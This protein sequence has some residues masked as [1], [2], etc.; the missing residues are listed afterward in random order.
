MTRP[1]LDG[2][3]NNQRYYRRHAK[4]N[5]ERVRAWRRA[6][7]DRARKRVKES[8]WRN[9]ETR[10]AVKRSEKF[11]KRRS[12][13][14]RTEIG[15]LNGRL[16]KQGRRGRGIVRLDEWLTLL[17]KYDHKCAY[18]GYPNH[19]EMDHVIPISRGGFH[20]IANI[21]PACKACNSSKGSDYKTPPRLGSAE[22]F[23]D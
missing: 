22:R 19:I 16:R 23:D 18:C 4:Q 15:Q 9:V 11:K 2:L 7:P 3:T 14:T 8:Y 1:V 20:V 6:N 10:R 21:L 13:L 17:E 12:E 5:T